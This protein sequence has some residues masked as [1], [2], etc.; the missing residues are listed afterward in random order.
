MLRGSWSLWVACTDLSEYG[1]ARTTSCRTLAHCGYTPLDLRFLSGAQ[2]I[3]PG[4]VQ[5]QDQIM[6][7]TS[8]FACRKCHDHISCFLCSIHVSILYGHTGCVNR[9][10]W[11]TLHLFGVWSGKTAGGP[12]FREASEGGGGSAADMGRGGFA[13]DMEYGICASKLAGYGKGRLRRGYGIWDMR[14]Q[15]RWIW[16]GRCWMG[17]GVRGNVWRRRILRRVDEFLSFESPSRR[18][19]GAGRA[20]SISFAGFRASVL[21]QER[22]SPYR[23]G[24]G[25][26]RA[27]GLSPSAGGCGDWRSCKEGPGDDGCTGEK[28]PSGI[29]PVVHTEKIHHRLDSIP[30]PSVFRQGYP[31]ES[32]PLFHPLSGEAIRWSLFLSSIRCP[33]KQS[34]GLHSSLPS[35]VRRSDPLDSTPIFHPLSGEAIRW[36]PLLSSIRCPAKRSVGLHSSL[37]SVVRQ[38]Y[39][40]SYTFRKPSTAPT[41]VSDEICVMNEC[42][43]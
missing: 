4:F 29:G 18:T 38:G 3:I 20:A 35:V 17:F 43:D 1:V 2:F 26:R 24:G 27:C 14:E 36:T 22:R 25:G 37:P 12:E 39:P 42:G 30:L 34:V 7:K 28:P 41:S 21:R 32:I 8:A 15:A 5:T 6:R 31:L 33:A 9:R 23:R 19:P 40:W 11:K 16:E 10:D 13:A